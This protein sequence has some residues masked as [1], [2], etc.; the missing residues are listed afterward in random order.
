MT[1]LDKVGMKCEDAGIYSVESQMKT[2]SLWV[3]GG[4][5]IGLI[6]IEGRIRVKISDVPKMIEELQGLFADYKS[7]RGRALPG[8]KRERMNRCREM[9]KEGKTYEEI[10]K[11]THLTHKQVYNVDHR[12]KTEK[13]RRRNAN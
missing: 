10:E 2:R 1:D 7:L 6:T 12:M 8:S 5:E 13:K 4:D 9:L 3:L 11:E